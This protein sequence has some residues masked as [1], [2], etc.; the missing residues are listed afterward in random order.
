MSLGREGP[1]GWTPALPSGYSGDPPGHLAL[2]APT[3]AVKILLSLPEERQLFL[4]ITPGLQASG[5]THLAFVLRC[6][7]SLS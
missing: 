4:P 7:W 1:A 5:P 6:P 3:Q 2:P